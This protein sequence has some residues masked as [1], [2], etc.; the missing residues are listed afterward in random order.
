M[1]GVVAYFYFT[2]RKPQP[3]TWS[4]TLEGTEKD[5]DVGTCIK[6]GKDVKELKTESHGCRTLFESFQKA[7]EEYASKPALGSRPVLKIHQEEK[8][9]HGE[10]KRWLTYEKG[11]YEFRTY[12]ETYQYTLEFASGLLNLGLKPGDKFALYNETCVEW[13][14]AEQACYCQNLTV[15]TVYAN[16]GAEGLKYA[17]QEAEITHIFTGGA[18]LHN[19]IEVAPECPSLKV[20]IYSEDGLDDHVDSLKE[21]HQI[22]HFNDVVETG[23]KNMHEPTPPK[24]EDIAC[25]MYTSGSTGPPKG[26]MIT[27]GNMISAVGGYGINFK[28]Q[29]DDCYLNYLPLA[30]VLAMVIEN[31]CIRY[32]A[33]IGYGL[34]VTL[35]DTNMKNCLGD[36]RELGPTAFAGVPLVYDKIKAG[37]ITQVNN[38]GA[39]TKIIFQI[40]LALK[41][42]ATLRGRSTP[43]L[44][45]IVFNKFKTLLGGKMRWMVSGGAPLSAEAHLYLKSCFGIPLLQGYGLTETCGAGAVMRMP[46]L[47]LG[48]VGAPVDC[49]EIKL[50]DVKDMGY[51][52]SNTP[53]PQGEVW[54]RG[55]C[56]SAGYFKHPEKTAEVFTKDG[57][58]KTGDIGEWTEAGQLK[59]IDRKKNLIKGPSGEY[60]ALEK[61]ECVFKNCDWVVSLCAYADSYRPY[62]VAIVQPQQQKVLAWGASKGLKD[63]FEDLCHKKE[64][65]KA[66][67]DEL[68]A[69]GKAAG[70]KHFELLQ[71]VVLVPEEWS[72]ANRMLTAAMKLNRQ[73]IYKTFKAEIDDMY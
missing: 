40:A 67:C 27:H 32:G 44:D 35:T 30:H 25:I 73:N 19:L 66:I 72:S 6:R 55:P 69:V 14:V 36:M 60:I 13:T 50:V 4:D 12:A 70:L 38:S 59:I 46:D 54:M 57:W 58:F 65:R 61:L 26:V 22:Y 16:L 20:I 24:P 7:C 2:Y 31:A 37:I 1:A 62:N 53:R 71:N 18:L 51:E 41:K 52:A 8:I 68:N 47:S 21:N 48:S 56:I 63:S 10:K 11:P 64:L 23:K 49:L 28:V 33:K 43:L 42:W 17:I 15:L 34:P 29:P 3:S 9:V 5:G 39:A 45:L